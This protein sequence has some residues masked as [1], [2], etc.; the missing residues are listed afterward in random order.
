VKLYFYHVDCDFWSS[1]FCHEFSMFEHAHFFFSLIVVFNHLS[2]YTTSDVHFIMCALCEKKWLKELMDPKKKDVLFSSMFFL[3]FF[4]WLKKYF[5]MCFDNL[6]NF[7]ASHHYCIAQSLWYQL[8]YIFTSM[9]WV[10]WVLIF[11]KKKPEALKIY[12]FVKLF[13]K[14]KQKIFFI[15]RWHNTKKKVIK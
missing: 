10:T 2:C 13:K 7:Y 3:C 11:F 8:D 4:F 1:I 5:D 15:K 9:F 6:I 14:M 12:I